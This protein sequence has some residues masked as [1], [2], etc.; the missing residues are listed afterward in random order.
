MF[1]TILLPETKSLL[2][3]LTKINLPKASYLVG[4]TAIALQLGHR[5][6]AD[7]DF[8]TPHEFVER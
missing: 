3:K 6:S 2:Q 1:E 7:L 4:G 8:F 5:R